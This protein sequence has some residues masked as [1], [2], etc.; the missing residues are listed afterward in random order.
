MV[1][2]TVGIPVAMAAT[3]TTVY[4][5]DALSEEVTLASGTNQLGELPWGDRTKTIGKLMVYDL[6]FKPG[7]ESVGYSGRLDWTVY[8]SWQDGTG[9]SKSSRLFG[10]N[11]S[12]LTLGYNA[13]E[14]ETVIGAFSSHYLGGTLTAGQWYTARAEVNLPQHQYRVLLLNSEGTVLGKTVFMPL[15]NGSNATI[16]SDNV[17][18]DSDLDWA[19][20]KMH[21]FYISSSNYNPMTYRNCRIYYKTYTLTGSATNGS[22]QCDGATLSN[23]TVEYNT[24]K[25]LSFLPEEGYALSSVTVNGDDRMGDVINNQLTL[26]NFEEDTT[27]VANFSEQVSTECTL[28]GAIGANGSV[29]V[30]GTTFTNGQTLTVNRGDALSVVV[31]P[32]ADYEIDTVALN[33]TS[34]TGTDGTYEA[35][36]PNANATLTVTFKVK[37]NETLVCRFSNFTDETTLTEGNTANALSAADAA[38]TVGKFLTFETEFKPGTDSVGYSGRKDWGFGFYW[39]D[40][41]GTTQKSGLFYLNNNGLTLGYDAIQPEMEIGS[42]NYSYIGGMLTAGEWYTVRAEINL[43]KHEYRMLILNSSGT[44]LGK[45]AFIP[46]SNKLNAVIGSD[47]VLT[48]S[49]LDW[50]SAKITRIDVSKNYNTLT[51]RNGRL[52]YK[53]Y[54]LTGSATNG[55]IQ[56]DGAELESETVEY[57]SSKTLT[58]VPATEGSP[59]TSVT[60]NGVDRTGDVVN[61]QLTLTNFEE[62]TNVVARFSNPVSTEFILTGAIGAN[63]RVTVNG[64]ALT[65]GQTLTVNQGETLNV[66]VT[67]NTGYAVDAVALDGTRLT[68]TNG[69]YT[70]TMPNADA[71]LA[72][73][74]KEHKGVTAASTYYVA[75]NGSDDAAGTKDAPFATIEKARDVIAS[76]DLPEGGV[77]VYIRGGEYSVENTIH[78]TSQNSGEEGKPIIYQ[79]YPGEKVT[80]MGGKKLDNTKMKKV[81]DSARLDRL[82]DGNAKDHLMQIDLGAQ[83]IELEALQPFGWGCPDYYP[84]QIYMNNSL[85]T[86]ARWPN[87]DQSQN[88]IQAQPV[89]EGIDTTKYNGSGMPVIMSYTDEENRSSKWTVNPGDAYIGGAIVFNWATTSLRIANIDTVNKQVT[90]ID[91]STYSLVPGAMWGQQYK[92]YF[93]NIFEEIDQPGESYY[94]RDTGILY[95]YPV[96]DIGNAEMVAASLNKELLNISSASYLTFKDI[97][98]K[99]GRKTLVSM[100][101]TSDICIDGAELSGTAQHAVSIQNAKNTTVK[102]CHIYNTAWSG[103]DVSKCGSRETLTSSGNIFENN[104]FHNCNLRPGTRFAITLD[105]TVGDVIRHNEFNDLSCGA[106]DI[107]ASN[108]ILI[109]YNKVLNSGYLVTDFGTIY[110]GRDNSVLGMVIRYNYFENIG[111]GLKILEEGYTDSIFWDDGAAGP[112]LYGNV[113]Y[114]GGTGRSA[115]RTNGGEV[116]NIHNNVFVTDQEGRLPYAAYIYPWGPR[117]YTYNGTAVKAKIPACNWLYLMDMRSLM[118]TTEGSPNRVEGNSG[119]WNSNAENRRTLFWSDFW[120]EYYKG[121]L[122]EKTLNLYSQDKYNTAKQFFDKKDEYGLLQ[123]LDENLPNEYSN[124]THDNIL[125]GVT[126]LLESKSG[127]YG[128]HYDNYSNENVN[129]AKSLFKDYGTDFSLTEKGLAEVRKS[130]PE[131]ENIPFDQIGLLTQVGGHKPSVTIKPEVFTG[132]A[133]V[134]NEISPYYTF[135]DADGDKEGTTLVYWYVSDNENG[136]YTKLT[137]YQGHNLK[138]TSDGYYKYEIIPYDTNSMRGEAVMSEPIAVRQAGSVDYSALSSALKTARAALDGAVAGEGPGQYPQ[139]A[140]D[141]LNAAISSAQ[142]VANNANASQ[143]AV[144]NETTKLEAAIE[145]FL[146]ARIPML[147]RDKIVHSNINSILKD[148]DNWVNPGSS[149]SFQNGSLVLDAGASFDLATY[150]AAKYLNQEFSFKMKI[151]KTDDDA[152]A[153]IYFRQLLTDKK[154]W[155]NNNAGYMFDIKGDIMNLQ[156]Y[157]SSANPP[158]IIETIDNNFIEFGKEYTVTLGVYDTEEEN[159]AYWEMKVDGKTVYSQSLDCRE[160][161]YGQEGY[162]GFSMMGGT[163]T[164]SPTE[165]DAT[166]LTATIGQ[167]DELAQS[168]TVGTEYG[169]YPSESLAALK[170]AIAAAE[171]VKA[172]EDVTQYAVDKAEEELKAAMKALLNSVIV[173]ETVT[174]NKTI[175]IDETLPNATINVEKTAN[176]VKLVTAKDTALPAISISAERSIG[177]VSVTIPEDTALSGAGTLLAVKELTAP[178]VSVNGTNMFTIQMAEGTL[179]SDHAIRILFPGQG[180]KQV[181]IITNGKFTRISKKV[182]EDSQQTADKELA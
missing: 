109:E 66:V 90:S 72:V 170:T 145:E 60:V 153:G 110:W 94:D 13:T 26:T 130:A 99:Y 104:Y 41:N 18:T 161:N 36:M 175:T 137:S 5:L 127:Y 105:E 10:L 70:A 124:K 123:Y 129:S 176:E 157:D 181:G 147:D 163:L 59:L 122:W 119:L 171:R 25:T 172:T 64:T 166:S 4:T 136:P 182:T 23:E 67:P 180:K 103:I 49:D 37:T 174:G 63:G 92:I 138:L 2:S 95:F 53:T 118:G 128:E 52:Y 98:F 117:Y 112:E 143:R 33:G 20:A 65:N 106:V 78:F 125:I 148:T 22:I 30:N 81:T 31:T 6:D 15:V 142:T 54:A 177:T 134:G 55:S 74:F 84:T 154:I 79:A 111:T 38:K 120:A 34:L 132:V 85:L 167:A 91:K 126:T 165:A 82:I 28:T 12:G 77:T 162:F 96:G 73:T 93:A 89:M 146:N 61:N 151:D 164:I 100:N 160:F 27:V 158:A 87:N 141:A 97:D 46:F 62:D 144:N 68:G 24:S 14:P 1:F 71:T 45:T 47:D 21:Y 56:C 11:N 42:I 168:V 35:T 88:L 102:G 149:M 114:N 17:L 8:F 133:T 16:G 155:T 86:Q 43:P 39:S 80:F 101:G 116:S 156:E 58:F 76:A 69:T 131:F 48:D 44:I 51:L 40:K 75:A 57:S 178:S 173:S 108:N 7:T 135:N 150:Q 29:T 140:V 152:W 3:E 115:I 179:T 169:Q 121:T 139:T 50:E 19:T 83:G 9:A 32:D 159:K 107:D 113:F